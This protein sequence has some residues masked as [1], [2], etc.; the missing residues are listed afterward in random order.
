M[1]GSFLPLATVAVMVTLS[2]KLMSVELA[3]T[4]AVVWYLTER[5]EMGSVAPA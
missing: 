4:V 5:A 3:V 1:G 2:P